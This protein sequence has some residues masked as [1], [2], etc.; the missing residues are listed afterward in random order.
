MLKNIRYRFREL[1]GN[2]KYLYKLL[3]LK[4]KFRHRIISI[5][6]DLCIEGFPRSA[7]S[8]FVN[9]FCHFNPHKK[10][11]HHI[12]VPVQ[13]LKSVEYNIPCIV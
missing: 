1:L 6:K 4:K 11:A 2:N 3:Y 8:F 5:D 12:H 13:V 9:I 7:N 10:I